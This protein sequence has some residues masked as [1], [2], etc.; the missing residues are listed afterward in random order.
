MM[1]AITRRLALR[2]GAPYLADQLG[3]GLAGDGTVKISGARLRRC[4]SR[5]VPETFGSCGLTS[6]ASKFPPRFP[7]G[8]GRGIGIGDG[9]AFSLETLGQFGS[10]GGRLMD[11]E[12]M[13]HGES[14]YQDITLCI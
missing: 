3:G 8:G 4:S 9:T 12:D 6:A 5:G 7:D 2:R 10:D 11:D 14:P 13:G 1:R